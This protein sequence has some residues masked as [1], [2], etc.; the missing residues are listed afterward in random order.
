MLLEASLDQQP[1]ATAERSSVTSASPFAPFY[2]LAARPDFGPDR[3]DSD[4][5]PMS[6]SAR[7]SRDR[8]ECREDPNFGR[9]R[10]RSQRGRSRPAVRRLEPAP[11]YR[12][13]NR[14][15]VRRGGRLSAATRRRAAATVRPSRRSRPG[16]SGTA[17]ARLRARSRS[18]TRSTSGSAS[19]AAPPEEHP[20][21]L[22]RH[23]EVGPPL[24]VP[25]GLDSEPG[26][27][28]VE[29]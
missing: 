2:V 18:R 12:R 3:P 25:R 7:S 28:V 1:R 26:E 4:G 16:T 9:T 29:L 22:P 5:T 13:T 20:A 11:Q 10:I 6:A 27:G 8:D 15:S 19:P 21:P 17:R 23:L 24:P 14:P